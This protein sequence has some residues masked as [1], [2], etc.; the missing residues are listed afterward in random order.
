MGEREGATARQR[1]VWDD[2]AP[3][4]DRAMRPLERLWFAGGREWLGARARGRVL[5]VAI[6]TGAT[7]PHYPADASVT[8]LDLSPRM[9]A[10]AER[11]AAELGRAIPLVEGDAEH[12][13]FPGASFDTVVCALGLCSI[14]RPAA[15]VA[16]MHR[17]LVPGG[18]LLLLDH[19]ASSAL[20][21]RA[22][23]RLVEQ[24]TIRVAGEHFTR[25]QLP[26][27]EA[28]GFEV[29]EAERWKAGTIERLAAVKR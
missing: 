25:R 28:A 21:L 13:P 22:A 27:V 24:L 20:P 7:L 15:A 3:R 23:Q 6:G 26:L 16:E 17:V 29:V 1:R 10:V 9:L 14:P 12:L 19:V 8:G 2:A 4:Y 5:D 11:R 18:T